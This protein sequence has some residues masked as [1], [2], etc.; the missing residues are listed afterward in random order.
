LYPKNAII[1]THKAAA[2]ACSSTENL[3]SDPPS[4]VAHEEAPD[5]APLHDERPAAAHIQKTSASSNFESFSEQNL[6]EKIMP[7]GAK[8]ILH[9]R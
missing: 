8:P 5:G 7:E 3:A 2:S 4:A 9:S 6:I 1:N